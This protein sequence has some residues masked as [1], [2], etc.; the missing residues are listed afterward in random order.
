MAWELAIEQATLAKGQSGETRKPFAAILY[1]LRPH[2]SSSGSCAAYVRDVVHILYHC[3]RVVQRNAT[4]YYSLTHSAENLRF[5]A[6]HSIMESE[7]T[8]R[9]PSKSTDV[10][11]YQKPANQGLHTQGKVLARLP[12]YEVKSQFSF[13]KRNTGLKKI[14]IRGIL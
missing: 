3:S 4:I 7:C 9:W 1:L 12:V 2:P 10:K 6:N 13:K 14:P 11:A 5:F 8:Y